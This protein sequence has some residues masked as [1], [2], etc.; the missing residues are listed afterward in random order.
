MFPAIRSLHPAGR[1]TV[2]VLLVLFTLLVGLTGALQ[3]DQENPE[4]KVLQLKAQKA[5]TDQ[6][7]AEAAGIDQEIAQKYPGTLERRFAVQMLGSIYEDNMVNIG[8]ALKWDREYLKKY[9]NPRQVSY[10]NEK[11]ASLEKLKVQEDTFRIYKKIRFGGEG[12][13]N[14]VKDFEVLLKEHPGFLLKN[15]VERELAYAYARLDKRKE[16]FQA[17][18]NIAKN[19]PKEVSKLDRAL[20]NDNERYWKMQRYSWVA[21]SIVALLWAL[22]LSM[23]PWK[24]L[25]RA[26]VRMFLILSLVWVLIIAF[27]LPG[28][29][30]IDTGADR[31]ILKD[32]QLF[33][34]GGLNLSVLLW[35]FLLSRGSFWLFRPR[36]LRFLSPLLTLMMTVAV[37]YLFVVYQPNGPETIDVFVVKYKYLMLKY[38]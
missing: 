8:K 36:E 38:L 25:S 22:A 9:A 37:F 12:D 5:F 16:S 3:A 31:I 17:I 33:L 2:L 19:N 35:I 27:S 7:Y 23:R 29:Y 28:F 24:H 32:S 18:Q 14:M 26:S 1:V 34:A 15:D 20:S 21:W 11:I 13:A 10:Y 30:G 4:A 6:H